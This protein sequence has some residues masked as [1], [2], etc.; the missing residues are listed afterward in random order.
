[1]RKEDN[2]PSDPSH[3]ESEIESESES[4]SEEESPSPASDDSDSD[5]CPTKGVPP[6]EPRD[7]RTRTPELPSGSKSIVNHGNPIHTTT[8]FNWGPHASLHLTFEARNQVTLSRESVI[9]LM[10]EL[11]RY[12]PTLGRAIASD[13]KDDNDTL[14]RGEIERLKH[15]LK[16]TKQE[17]S[18][19]RNRLD[20]K[21]ENRGADNKIEQN[22]VE[23]E[24]E[25]EETTEEEEEESEEEESEEEE[26]EGEDMIV[27]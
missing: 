24:E 22:V 9:E 12:D 15:Q 4:E 16:E 13:E 25:E 21:K 20:R 2:P 27:D 3:D 14:L 23:V 7:V 8:S 17:N 10:D 26:S 19:L 11:D 5:F 1:M 6:R 18:L